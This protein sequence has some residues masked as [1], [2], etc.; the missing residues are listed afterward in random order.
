[1][2]VI[3]SRLAAAERRISDRTSSVVLLKF[4]DGS[5]R[6]VSTGDA[7]PF[8]QKPAMTKNPVVD[9]TGGGAGAGQLVELLRGML[10]PTPSE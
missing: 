4:A 5:T 8:F 3:L 10:E 6:R 2:R 9:V 7:I 1:M